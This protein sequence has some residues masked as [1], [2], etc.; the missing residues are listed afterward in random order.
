M[1]SGFLLGGGEESRTPVQKLIRI[2][3]SER[4]HFFKF[5]CTGVKCQTRALGSSEAVIQAG[6]DLYSL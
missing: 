2:G 6:A 1:V 4:R 3:I 5:P